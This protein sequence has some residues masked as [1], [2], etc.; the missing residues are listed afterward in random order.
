MSIHF[1]LSAAA[2]ALALIASPL[3]A[4]AK[5]FVVPEKDALATINFPDDWEPEATDNGVEVTSPDSS[6]YVSAQGVS[7]TSIESA[8]KE[9]VGVLADQGLVIDTKSMKQ[10]DEEWNGMKIHSMDYDAK[11]NDGDTE[12]NISVIETRDPKKFLIMMFWGNKEAQKTNGEAIGQMMHS[13]QL[14]K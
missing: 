14:T 11:D 5:V 1:K 13:V 6:V 4:L 2:I 3:P 10:K 12:F 9:S 7:G 8:V